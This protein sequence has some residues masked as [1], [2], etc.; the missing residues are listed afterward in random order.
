MEDVSYSNKFDLRFKDAKRTGL[1]FTDFLAYQSVEERITEIKEAIATEKGIPLPNLSIPSA[2]AGGTQSANGVQNE[3]VPLPEDVTNVP[4]EGFDNLDKDAQD[5]WSKYMRKTIRTQ[6]KLI[7][8]TG[9]QRDLMKQIEES[10]LAMMRGDPTGLVMFHYD[11]K[12]HGESQTRP[13]LRVTPMRDP[14]YTRLVSS[15]LLARNGCPIESANDSVQL[16]AGEIAVLI[17]GGK[18]GNKN[19]LLSPWQSKDNKA[20]K[21]ED[22]AP[23]V[24]DVDDEDGGAGAIQSIVPSILNIVKDESSI[25]KWKQKVRGTLAIKQIEQAHVLSNSKLSLPERARKHYAGTNCGDSLVGVEI[26]SYDAIWKC[27]WKFKKALYGKKHLIAVGGKTA[28]AEPASGPHDSA[29]MQKRTDDT[30]EPVCW[31]PMPFKFYD[32]LIH[33]F[34]VKLFFDLVTCDAELAWT[35]LV[36]FVGYVGICFTSEHVEM[37]E[38]HLMTKLKDAMAETGS[39]LYNATYAAATSKKTEAGA[40]GGTAIAKAK[41][42]GK[43]K[44][45]GA[46]KKTPKPKRAPVCGEPQGEDDDASSLLRGDDE[47]EE[48]EEWDPLAEA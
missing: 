4:H 10:P 17:D 6:I 48:E 27:K 18:T 33:C 22:D 8:D 21:K 16:Q 42:N 34:F 38:A 5:E 13:D 32:D 35:C 1:E 46:P 29:A 23:E 15:V 14:V 30:V 19:R 9:S 7:A 2:G 45:Q 11:V 31:H 43:P 47:E 20:K 26:P 12:K 28:G 24:D 25:A 41:A 40:T 36:N 44:R 37:V 39:P 3:G